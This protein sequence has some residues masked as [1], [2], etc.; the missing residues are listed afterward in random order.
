MDLESRREIQNT[1]DRL[2]SCLESA[3][4]VMSSLSDLYI[5]NKEMDEGRKIVVEME[6][7][8][9]EFSLTYEAARKRTHQ[10]SH[11]IQLQ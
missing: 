8:E 4:D 5:K 7:L 10:A 2:Y 11:Q 9:E 3:I 6:K 1:C